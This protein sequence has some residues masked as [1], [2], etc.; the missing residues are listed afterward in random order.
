MNEFLEIVKAF[1][2]ARGLSTTVHVLFYL[3]HRSDMVHCTC[4]G[5]GDPFS[6][7]LNKVKPLVKFGPDYYYLLVCS[8]HKSSLI[9]FSS[10][11]YIVD[12]EL[13][14]NCSQGPKPE[15]G[16]PYYGT[17]YGHS[18]AEQVVLILIQLN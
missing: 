4:G 14:F 13:A 9:H 17:R 15:L 8:R 18:L 16:V 6:I 2:L 7:I 3:H 12:P 5:I 10:V 1:H 11:L